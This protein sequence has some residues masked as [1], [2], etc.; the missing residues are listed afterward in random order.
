MSDIE[1]ALEAIQ[2]LELQKQQLIHKYYEAARKDMEKELQEATERL[3]KAN[4]GKSQSCLKESKIAYAMA[5]M[6]EIL[7]EGALTVRELDALCKADGI[8]VRTLQ[9]AKTELNKGHMIREWS[10]GVGSDHI[11]FIEREA[12][13]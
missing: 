7:S 11:W 5:K 1:S 13:A 8:S 12:E 2:S 6:L 4:K 3:E 9:R 10:E